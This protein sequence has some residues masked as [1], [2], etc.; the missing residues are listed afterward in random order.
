MNSMKF[1]IENFNL[2]IRFI[3]SKLICFELPSADI[4]AGFDFQPFR[5]DLRSATP[6]GMTSTSPGSIENITITAIVR[7]SPILN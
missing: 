6:S 4:D 7:A 2:K 1:T 3:S 5:L